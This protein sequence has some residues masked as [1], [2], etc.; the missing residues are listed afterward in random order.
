MVERSE[1][2]GGLNS[3]STLTIDDSVIRD[4]LLREDGQWGIGVISQEY[5]QGSPETTITGSVLERQRLAGIVA[6]G[7]VIM[8][9]RTVVAHNDS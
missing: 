1:E 5:P 6:T 4:P 8:V 7:W 3:G 9:T 2:V